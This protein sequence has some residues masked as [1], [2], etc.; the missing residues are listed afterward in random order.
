VTPSHG[1]EPFEP[2]YQGKYVQYVLRDTI[3]SE[4]P[5]PINR[6]IFNWRIFPFRQFIKYVLYVPHTLF[7]RK[8][9]SR[10]PNLKAR[11]PITLLHIHIYSF[12]DGTVGKGSGTGVEGREIRCESA[13]RFLL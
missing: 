2:R 12:G 10:I 5:A 11:E 7:D 4:P 1:W 9:L 13:A 8:K 6:N 3:E